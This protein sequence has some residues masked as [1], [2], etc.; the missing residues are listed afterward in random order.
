MDFRHPGLYS[1]DTPGKFANQL[2]GKNSSGKPMIS[3]DKT[4]VPGE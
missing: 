3:L 4:G 1:K 2:V